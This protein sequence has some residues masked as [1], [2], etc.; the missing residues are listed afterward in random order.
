MAKLS[1]SAKLLLAWCFLR[2]CA[3][4]FM[5]T[6]CSSPA[7]CASLD[8]DCVIHPACGFCPSC[9]S[10]LYLPRC[11]SPRVHLCSWATLTAI[12][13]LL[14]GLVLRLPP[15]SR[16]CHC[17]SLRDFLCVPGCWSPGEGPKI[18][19]SSFGIGRP[20]RR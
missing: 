3:E 10:A 17:K 2:L 8:R 15:L 12:T 14:L 1:G 18:L 9:N 6:F 19:T 4:L 16:P 11:D 20:A 13:A 7:E 5:K